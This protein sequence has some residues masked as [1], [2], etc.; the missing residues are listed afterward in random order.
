M[1]LLT[2]EDSTI[3]RTY[4]KEMAKLIGISVMYQFPI[5]MKFSL[6]A[7]EDPKGFSPEEPMDIIFEENPKMTTLRKYG[8]VSETSDDKP[9]IAQLPYDAKNLC[10]GCR[11]LI[12]SPFPGNKGRLFVVT[13]ITGNLQFPDSWV[14]KLAPVMH[15]KPAK[16]IDYSDTNYNF[17]KVNK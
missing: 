11:I 3:F 14:C 4:F 9:Y 16:P 7:E 8:W 5:D 13:E 6:Y 1:G 17:L 2:K 12:P 15:D 10:K